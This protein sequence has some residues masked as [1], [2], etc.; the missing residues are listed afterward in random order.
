MP[1]FSVDPDDL[2]AAGAFADG[3]AE[4]LRAAAAGV[5]AAGRSVETAAGPESAE[6]AAAFRA[7]VGV[8]GV[9]ADALG[10]AVTLLARALAEAGSAY[11]AAE[12][13]VGAMAA[14][15]ASR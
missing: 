1:R 7:Y 14:G 13:A 3:A 8:D 15:G 10:E 9:T 5:V 12:G 11:A 2:T 4:T 6:V